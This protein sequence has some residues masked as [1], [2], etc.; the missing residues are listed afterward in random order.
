ML[1][2]VI[3]DVLWFQLQTLK[4]GLS[5][6]RGARWPLRH[7]SRRAHMGLLFSKQPVSNEDRMA[8]KEFVERKIKTNKVV[9]F[10]KSYCPYCRR[11]GHTFKV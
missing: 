6:V 11:A 5:H 3:H 1:F 9:V 2:V 10:S 8:A 4:P 7:K